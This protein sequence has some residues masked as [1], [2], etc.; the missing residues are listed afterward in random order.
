MTLEEL[1]P[2]T[3]VGV[4]EPEPDLFSRVLEEIEVGMDVEGELGAVI[5][6]FENGVLH[7]YTGILLAN[8][9]Q[10]TPDGYVLTDNVNALRIDFNRSLFERRQY[11]RVE[12][13]KSTGKVPYHYVVQGPGQTYNVLNKVPYVT[14]T[15]N[16]E[17]YRNLEITVIRVM[18]N[19]SNNPSLEGF[20]MIEGRLKMPENYARHTISTIT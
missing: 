3:S 20:E 17:E 5:M 13:K 4:L 16:P 11:G 19:I 15:I 7:G 1:R 10:K 14:S 12:I 6:P 9:A 2:G 8:M 18:A